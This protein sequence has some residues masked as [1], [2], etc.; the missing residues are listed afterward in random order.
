MANQQK[1]QKPRG[2]F[3]YAT[4]DTGTADE[5]RGAAERVRG[6]MRE[7]VVTVGRELLAIKKHHIERGHFEAWVRR[8]CS[9]DIRTAQRAMKAAQLVGK[10]DKLSY[11]PAGG[12]LALSSRAAEPVAEEI[13]KRIEQ[14]DRPTAAEIKREIA[15][16]K[17][18]SDNARTS[19]KPVEKLQSAVEELDS[20]ELRQ[21]IVWFDRYREEHQGDIAAPGTSVAVPEG[22]TVPAEHFGNVENIVEL[23]SAPDRVQI[24]VP[25]HL[26]EGRCRGYLECREGGCAAVPRPRPAGL[27]AEAAHG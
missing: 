9:L 16:A 12:L 1:R 17:R 11:L 23:P 7:S 5:M 22:A 2:G 24:R 18:G 25:C 26:G 21:F 8:E 13:I 27:I 15:A 6:F 4:L 19:K 3:D 14:G 10:N 20:G